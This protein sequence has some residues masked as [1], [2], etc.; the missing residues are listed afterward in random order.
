MKPE[1]PPPKIVKNPKKQRK[2]R[3]AILR[4]AAAGATVVGAALLG[5]FPVLKKWTERLRPPG[6][7]AEKDFLAACIKCGQC[8]QVCPVEA[9]KLGDLDEGFGVGVPYIDARTQAC[10]FSCDATQC[11]LACPTEALS[12][13]IDKKEQVRMGLARLARPGAC[14]A[15]QGKGFQ[16]YARG[17]GFPGLHRYNEIDRWKPIP[18]GQ[19]KYDLALCDLC[20]RECPI[21]GAI[22]LYR[23]QAGDD[24]F[25]GS[26]VITD[27]CVGCG[28]CEMIC[29]VEPAAI[30][31]DIRKTWG[32]V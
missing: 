14:L 3:R 24:D 11:I 9:I 32:D 28:M 23:I 13:K 18:L 6:A 19:Y 26:P 10:D 1:A 22:A 25:R 5:F 7:I 30:V 21:E 20:V 15:R 12:H 2:E 31:I 8:V 17:D 27:K 29:P 4:S 16:G